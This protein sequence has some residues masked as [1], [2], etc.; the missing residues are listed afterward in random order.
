MGMSISVGDVEV[1]GLS[2]ATV[3]YPWPLTELFPGV[4]EETWE[5]NRK[6]YP[7]VFAGPA[8]WRSDYTSYLLRTGGHVMLVEAGM[9]PAEAPLASVFGRSG[10]LLER[11]KNEGVHPE[12]ISIVVLSHLHPDH[13]GWNLLPEGDG[14]RLTFPNARYVVHRADWEAFH[15]PEVQAHFPFPFVAQTI[16]PLRDLGA[17]DL[18]SDDRWLTDEVQVIHTPGHTPGHISVLI[19]SHQEQAILLGDVIL[20]PL[21]VAEPSWNAMFDMDPQAAIRTRELILDRIETEAIV[22]GARHLPEPGF[23]RCERVGHRRLWRAI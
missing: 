22:A 12:D 3:E 1:T 7:E 9:G 15:R 11:M 20:H 5:A 17:L 19:T 8:S 10:L 23:G 2:D 4:S 18:V 14:Y 6:L 21:Q 16:S 13:V